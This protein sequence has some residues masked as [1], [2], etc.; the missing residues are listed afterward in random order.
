MPELLTFFCGENLNGHMQCKV[1]VEIDS[2]HF[3]SVLVNH[4]AVVFW[5]IGVGLWVCL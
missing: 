4:F 1:F 2:Y 5:P 3:I